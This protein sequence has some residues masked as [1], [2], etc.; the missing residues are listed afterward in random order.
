MDVFL[1]EILGIPTQ[2][3]I[4]FS[5]E[6]IP[7]STLVSKIPYRMSIPKSTKLKVQL[8]ELLDK[9]CI[10][11]SVSPWG[12]PILFVKKRDGTL[13]LCIDYR[14]L[15]KVTI[16]K[17]YHLRQIN[18]L[19]DRAGGDK[20]FPMGPRVWIHTWVEKGHSRKRWRMESSL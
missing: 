17:K 9:G 14:Q 10:K 6:I 2:W 5:I 7:A 20:F 13:R 15:N 11:P 18:D 8:Q 1:E 3:E 12:A 19:F 4:H 16:K